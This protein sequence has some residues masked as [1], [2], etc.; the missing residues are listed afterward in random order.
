MP[1]YERDAE[2]SA[3][4]HLLLDAGKAKEDQLEEV[5]EEHDRTG[6]DFITVLYNYAIVTEDELMALVAESLGSEV[7][8]VKQGDITDD[9][10]EQIP[11]DIARLYNIIPIKEEYNVLHVA[12]KDP[13]NYRMID[14]LPYL[15][16]RTAAF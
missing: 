14:E 13:M 4:W 12:A 8:D 11:P 15:W 9:L 6:R 5:Y 2:I 16:K 3:I 10:I 1:G 7:V